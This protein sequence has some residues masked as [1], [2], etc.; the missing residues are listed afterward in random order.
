MKSFLKRFLNYPVSLL[1]LCA[2]VF[3]SLFRPSDNASFKMLAGMDKAA[4]FLMYAGLGGVMWLEHYLSHKRIRYMH[5]LVMSFF[6]PVLFSGVMELLQSRFTT[7]RSGD[8]YDFL[9]N[10][11]GAAFANVACFYALRPVLDRRLKRNSK[12]DTI[13]TS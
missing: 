8:F 6:I 3:L 1:L 12:K 11:A 5:M 9:F 7:H 13:A 4:H 10:V 2:I